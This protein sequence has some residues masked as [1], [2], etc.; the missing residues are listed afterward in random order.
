MIKNIYYALIFSSLVATSN[1]VVIFD[2]AVDGNASSDGSAPTS[3]EFSL[4]SNEVLGT[5]STG[6]PINNT[7]NFYTFSIGEGQVLQSITLDAINVTTNA[8]AV[9]NDPGFYALVLGNTSTN[10]GGGFANLGGALY[11]PNDL[12]SNLL[13]Q[14]AGGGISGGS[15]FETIGEGEYTFVI[16]QTGDEINNFTL[17]FEVASIPEPSSSSLLGLAAFGLILRRRRS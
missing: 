12:G 10:P 4:G 7:R 5:V 2:D 16:Q 11:D 14:I 9:S 17:D 6:A 13:T 15:G 1:A 3:L 8:G